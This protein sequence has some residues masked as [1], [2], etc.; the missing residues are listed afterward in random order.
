MIMHNITVWPHQTAVTY[1]MLLGSPERGSWW[2]QCKGSSSS[3]AGLQ[4]DGSWF[5][6]CRSVA[7]LPT[8]RQRLMTSCWGRWRC[9]RWRTLTCDRSCRTTRTTWP[10]WRQRHP[11]WRSVSDYTVWTGSWRGV[12]SPPKHC[13]VAWRSDCAP[14]C[15]PVCPPDSSSCFCPKN[16]ARHLHNT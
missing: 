10:N 8:W 6:L 11:I 13:W 7:G 12:S 2:Q 3:L 5:A 1:K 14:V 4:C 16:S 9:W 15:P